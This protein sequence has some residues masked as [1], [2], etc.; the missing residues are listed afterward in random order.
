MEKDNLE[1]RD[2]DGRILR[3]IFRKQDGGH[4]LD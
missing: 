2:I 4:G 1:D 3:W